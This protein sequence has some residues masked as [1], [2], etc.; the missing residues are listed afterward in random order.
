MSYG[1]LVRTGL[2][3]I[4]QVIHVTIQ[5][6]S[7]CLKMKNCVVARIK[8]LQEKTIKIGHSI[9]DSV[10]ILRDNHLTFRFVSMYSLVSM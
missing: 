2:R 10:I 6:V 1:E 3:L 4:S 7:I 9:G 8:Q 5:I